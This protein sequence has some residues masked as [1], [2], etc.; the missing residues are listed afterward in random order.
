MFLPHDLLN[1]LVWGNEHLGYMLIL[2]K[3]FILQ[4]LDVIYTSDRFK[5]NDKI[6][7][8]ELQYLAFLLHGLQ[9]SHLMNVHTIGAVLHCMFFMFR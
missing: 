5:S 9:F 4:S 3:V 6:N 1:Q 7:E 8:T 2:I